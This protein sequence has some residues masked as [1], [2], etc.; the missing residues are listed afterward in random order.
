MPVIP[1]RSPPDDRPAETRTP[2]WPQTAWVNLRLAA[3][4]LVNQCRIP[5]AIQPMHINDKLSGQ[6]LDV[7]VGP[8]FTCISVNGRDYYF[9]RFSGRL[10]GTGVGCR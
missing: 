1:F 6:T 3:G 7:T 4:R 5:G 10:D 8:F 2:R 9:C